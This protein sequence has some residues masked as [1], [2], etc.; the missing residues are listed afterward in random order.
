MAPQQIK[1][2]LD[3]RPFIPFRLHLSD[4]SAYDVHD[5]S[6]AYVDMLFVTV[7]TEPDAESRLFRKSIQISPSHV[8]RNEPMPELKAS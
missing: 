3:A 8:S 5:P 4:G 7:G 6:D 2:N 1:K